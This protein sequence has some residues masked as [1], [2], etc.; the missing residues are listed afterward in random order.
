MTK[1]EDIITAKNR[2]RLRT[3]DLLSELQLQ[4]IISVKLYYKII[5]DIENIIKK[6]KYFRK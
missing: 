1:K 4:K 5:P 2:I 3:D 6:L